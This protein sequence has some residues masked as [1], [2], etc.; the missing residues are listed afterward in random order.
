MLGFRDSR[1]VVIQLNKC[2]HGKTLSGCLF[3]V[4]ANFIFLYF[5]I[6]ADLP[7]TAA[8][9]TWATW[10]MKLHLGSW[11]LIQTKTIL[12]SLALIGNVIGISSSG[13]GKSNTNVNSNNKNVSNRTITHTASFES[14]LNHLTV[15]RNT[16]RVIIGG[17]N[18]LYQL[19]PDLNVA[20]TVVTGPQN[21]SYDC[22]VVECPDKANKLP[23]DN[24][25]KVL[26]IDYSTSRLITCG[27]LFQV[28]TSEISSSKIIILKVPVVPLDNQILCKMP[29]FIFLLNLTEY[30]NLKS[31]INLKKSHFL[32]FLVYRSLDFFKRTSSFK[33]FSNF[34]NKNPLETKF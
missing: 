29:S 25:N 7:A 19:S 9:M 16:G 12:I 26:L 28:R 3:F 32:H 18:R 2:K 20:I 34:S 5:S 27:S 15:D 10:N 1:L 33:L 4:C 31:V 8:Y 14:P 11:L 17:K 30:Q 22:T 24:V 21:D 13:G 6:F 23:T